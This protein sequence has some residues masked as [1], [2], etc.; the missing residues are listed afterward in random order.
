MV[1]PLEEK[2]EEKRFPLG[3]DLLGFNE[4]EQEI[5]KGG[6]TKAVGWNH[7]GA[8]KRGLQRCDKR[9]EIKE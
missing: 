3:A 7:G 6:V 1:A 8:N 9:K 4:R 2:R 5:G